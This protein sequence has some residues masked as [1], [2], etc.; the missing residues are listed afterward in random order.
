[1]S[2]YEISM[3]VYKAI[4]ETCI[5]VMEYQGEYVMVVPVTVNRDV[6]LLWSRRTCI[7]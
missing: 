6:L 2:D 3:K 5:N 1:M 7:G 4:S